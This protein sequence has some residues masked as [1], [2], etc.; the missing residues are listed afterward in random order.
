M[1]NYINNLESLR[2]KNL[3]WLAMWIK[4]EV[5]DGTENVYLFREPNFFRILPCFVID[6]NST[7]QSTS[8]R[9]TNKTTEVTLKYS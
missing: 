4:D 9:E 5:K 6:S 2:S 1:S 8:Y 3:V 7:F